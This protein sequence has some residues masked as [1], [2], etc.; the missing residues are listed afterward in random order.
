MRNMVLGDIVYNDIGNLD[1]GTIYVNRNWLG[2]TGAL[3]RN[4]HTRPSFSLNETA[5]SSDVLACCAC[6]I[7]GDDDISRLK[8]RSLSRRT[9]NRRGDDQLLRRFILTQVK[10]NDGELAAQI[11]VIELLIRRSMQTCAYH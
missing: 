10:A 1:L 3:N 4:R 2:Y 6:A 7:N 9:R 8:S 11:F 5:H